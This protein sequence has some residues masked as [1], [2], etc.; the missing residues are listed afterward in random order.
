MARIAHIKRR[1][2][3]WALWKSRQAS[4]GLGFHSVNILA[5]DVWGRSSYNGASIPHFDEDAEET[6]QAVESLKLSKPH[7]YEMLDC[8]YMKDLGVRE[9]ARRMGRGES[10]IHQ[11]LDQADKAI[12][13]WLSDSAEEKVRRRATALAAERARKSSTP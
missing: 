12:D 8:I 6:N 5:L 3:N 4:N 7:L 9:T 13:A 1:L 10:T 11:Q 2:D